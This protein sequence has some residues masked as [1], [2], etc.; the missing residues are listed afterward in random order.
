MEIHGIELPD[1]LRPDTLAQAEAILSRMAA[2]GTL[3]RL[4]SVALNAFARDLDLFLEADDRLRSE[5]EAPDGSPLG[6]LAK[7]DR[8]NWA[9]SPWFVVRKDMENKMMAWMRE[10]GL[11]RASRMK[12][13]KGVDDEKESPLMQVLKAHSPN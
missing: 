11:T 2:A 3:D 4:D 1:T 6:M 7:S 9:V 10:F 13:E 5:G 8:G 12:L